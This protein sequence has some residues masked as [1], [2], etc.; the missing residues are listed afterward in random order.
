MSINFKD[1]SN[2]YHCYT[3]ELFEHIVDQST[4]KIFT[5]PN[6]LFFTLRLINNVM[7]ILDTTDESNICDLTDVE[8]SSYT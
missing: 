2:I 6:Y 3:E 1:H 4:N 8:S 7:S 5:N